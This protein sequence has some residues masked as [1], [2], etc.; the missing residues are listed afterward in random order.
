MPCCLCPCYWPPP[1]THSLFSPVVLLWTCG[2]GAT[3]W[4]SGIAVDHSLRPSK[5]ERHVNV[6][7]RCWRL[8]LKLAPVDCFREERRNQRGERGREQEQGGV[9]DANAARI[10]HGWRAAV[11]ERGRGAG[12]RN[13]LLSIACSLQAIEEGDGDMDVALVAGAWRACY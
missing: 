12:V 3:Q 13:W 5:G 7:G 1:L 8:G 6:L 4:S 10:G 9:V 11:V 2:Q